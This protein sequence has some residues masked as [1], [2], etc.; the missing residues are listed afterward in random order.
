MKALTWVRARPKALASA[1]GVTA[2][3]IAIATL[4][5]TYEGN[6]TTKVDLNDGGVWITKSSALM[7]GHFNNESTLL[8]GGLRTTGENFDILQ[9]AS[10]ILVVNSGESSVTAVDPARVSLAD[11]TTIPASAK[12]SLGAQTAAILDTSSGDLWVVPVKGLSGFEVQGTDPLLELG[13]NSDVAVGHDG[14]VYAL[15]AGD[16]EVI[17][18]RVDNEGEPL[19]PRTAS[20]GEI[21]DSIAPSITA[22]GQ[23]PVVLSP[24]DSAVMTPGGLRTKI[25]EADTAVLQQA[26]AETDAVAVATGSQ[27]LRVP[28]D[29][30]EVQETAAG[31]QGLPATPVSLRGCSYGAWAG[32]GRFVRECPADADDVAADIPEVEA[33]AVLTFRVNRDVIILN[34]TVSGAAW[35]ADES[36]RKVDNWSD[37]TPPEGETEDEQD[38]TEETIET[39]LPERSDVNTPPIAEDDSFGV[40]PGEST[41]LPV[42]DND[43]DPDGDV[44]V[45]TVQ[46][47]QPSI[48]T[49]Q[50]IYDGGSLQIAVDEDASG[51]STFT[52]EADDGRGGRDTA[53][54][55]LTVKDPETN[56][57]PRPKRA[58]ALAIESGGTVSYNVLPDWLDPE[59]DDVYLKSVIAAPGDE[60][61][62]STDGQITYRATASLQG[63][64]EIPIVIADAFGEAANGMLILDVRPAGS[65]L[66]KTNADHVMTRVG[67]QVTVAPLTNDTSSGREPLRLTRV[68]GDETP[69]ATIVPD[70]PNKTFTFSAPNVGVYYVQYEVAAGPNGVPGLVR[71]DVADAAEQDLPPIAVRDVALLPTGGEVLLGVLNNDTDPSGGIL[72]VQSVSVEPGSGL[73]VSVLNHETLRIGD[74]GALEEQVRITYRI[75]NGS[76]S[77]EG[78]VVV[79]PIPAPEKLLAPVANPDTAVVRAGDVVTI[80]VLDNDT[81]PNGDALHVEPKLI[82]PFVD[83][84]AGEIFV[85]QDVVRFKAGDEAKTVYATYEVSDTRGQKVGGYITI[86]ILAVDAENNAAPRPRDL[87]SRVLSGKSSNIAVPLDGIDA[88]GDSVELMGLASN[89]TKGRVTVEQNYITYESFAGSSGV[90]TFT[91]RVRDRLGKEGTATIRV[92]I[93]PAQDTNQAPYAVKDSIVV[94]PGRE[95]AVPVLENDSDPEGDEIALVTDG[96]VLPDLDGLSAR[97]SGDR[98]LVQAPDRPVETSLQYAISDARG[99]MADAVLQI[100]VDEDVP[101]LAPVARDDR[102]RAEDLENGELTA[103]VDILANDEDPDG[104]TEALK[105]EV[106]AGGT[107]LENGNV[108]VTI[109]D[110]TQ[111]IRYSLTDVDG[112]STSAFIFVPAAPDLRPWSITTTPVEV[113]SGETKVLPLA[114]YVQAA[115]GVSVVI[116]EQAKV[117][118]AHADGANLVQDAR[119]LVYTSASRYFGDDAITFEVTDGTGPD[120]PNGRKSTLSI[121]IKVLPPANQQPKF[122]RAEVDVAPG[123]DASTLDLAALT[124]DPD[125]E[126]GHEFRLVGSPGDGLSARVEGST[127]LVEA[128]SNAKKGTTTTLTIRVSDGETDPIE[129]T[130]IVRV[131]ASTRSLATANTDTIDEAHQGE[132]ITVPVLANDFNP[133]PETPLTL[134][135]AAPETGNGVAKIDGDEVTVTPSAKFVGS[136]VIRYTV[137]DATEDVDRQVEGRIVLTVQGVPDAPGR[138]RVTSVQDRTVVVTFSAPSNNGAEIT[139]YT[140]S[141]VTGS[142][143]SKQCESTTCTLDGLTNN[144][145]YTFEVVA[146]NRVGDSEASGPSELARPDAR[147]DAP[148]APTLAFGDKSLVVAWATPTTPGSPVESYTLQ[149]SPAPPSGITQKTGVTGNSMVWEGLENGTSYQVQVQAHNRAPEPSTWSGWSLSQIPAGPPMQPGAPTTAELSP[150]GSQAQMNVSWAAPN[151]NGAAISGYQMQV[152]RGGEVTRTLSIAAGQTS[153]AVTVSTSETGY[154]Y[155]VRA[156]NK[157]GGGAW[158]DASPERRAVIAPSPPTGVSAEPHDRNIT[159]AYTPGARNGAREGEVSYQ[160]M[161]NGNGSWNTLSG[162]TISGLTNG[163]SYAVQIR[164]VATVSGTTYAGDPSAASAAVIPYGPVNTP[165]ATASNNGTS[166]TLGWSAPA[167]NGRP[168]NVMQINVNGAGWENVGP[169]GSRIAGN[170]YQQTHTIQVRAYDSEGQ[171]SSEAAASARTNDPPPPR[172]WV[173]SGDAVEEPGC[174]TCARFV[175]NTKDFVAGNY[176]VG[177]YSDHPSF[178]ADG[179][180]FTGGKNWDIPA[181]DSVQISCFLGSRG[182]GYQVWVT[183]DGVAYERRSWD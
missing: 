17:T 155:K 104:T 86:Q 157:A 115:G 109:G 95:V 169:S 116:T 176:E 26:S 150:V 136:L 99:A 66:P 29:G 65:T 141:S 38:T 121:P 78:E 107:P 59:G 49:V 13:K 165:T 50:P 180:Y 1:A 27:L 126:D 24:A 80:P 2:G 149:I 31:G 134:V 44:L 40:R 79:I 36:L 143:Y 94:R 30:S 81:H 46:D 117:S 47:D 181:N 60:V 55:T 119:T 53:T 70:Y 152:I 93:A 5:F 105:V 82:E 112:L 129:G 135:S 48:G 75:S 140:V 88:D 77:A 153:Q 6:P 18:I 41:S 174:P 177:C 138:P 37:L 160:Y 159:V 12:V 21:D 87:T 71:I 91:Y 128:A 67:E 89:P 164:G 73:S 7:V 54:V 45:A 122:T 139:G 114:E 14:T 52:Y 148:N 58:T 20:L 108:Q 120:D 125:P 154:T 22:V 102:V 145:E 35:L 33:S 167:T 127:L 142:N 56:T 183:I 90:D 96:L 175:I 151:N 16:A 146:T 156:Q 92:G 4:A 100:T 39:T 130:V 74:Q 170:G 76:K 51:S 72:V 57:A 23:I 144:V 34:D 85:S 83:S 166:V 3:V 8:D 173:T 62:F 123:E 103:D 162:T 158:S 111:L 168:I 10:T 68:N 32:S 179:G 147:P 42:L 63:R 113:V 25:T 19:E 11:S 133:F 106:G 118:A 171:L 61:E 28:L 69:G 132:T 9:D 178:A 163:T 84:D 43:N 97:V 182:E 101:L 131:S 15:S 161:L 124:S 110:E 172:A 137:R 98:V 64:K